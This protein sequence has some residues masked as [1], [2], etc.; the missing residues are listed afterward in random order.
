[1][2]NI[3]IENSHEKCTGNWMVENVD[4]TWQW[5][6]FYL[7]DWGCRFF[8]IT[9]DKSGLPDRVII[10]SAIDNT[11]ITTISIDEF[12]TTFADVVFYNVAYYKVRFLNVGFEL[13]N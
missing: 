11:F 6:Y 13:D 2:E 4:Y 3:I 7:S 9:P 12:K 10:T 5:K 1:M 8:E